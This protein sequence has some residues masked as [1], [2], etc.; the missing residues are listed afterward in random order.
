MQNK[1]TQTYSRW[2]DPDKSFTTFVQPHAP[3]Y[4]VIAALHLLP[5]YAF[6]PGD[7][8]TNDTN[9]HGSVHAPQLLGSPR[10]AKT[11]RCSFITGSAKEPLAFPANWLI[12]CPCI[13][14]LLSV[15]LTRLFLSSTRLCWCS[16]SWN[17]EPL[18]YYVGSYRGFEAIFYSPLPRIQ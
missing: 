14:K 18:L 13:L 8:L 5:N 2:F 7:V 15:R 16:P 17:E 6:T 1:Q 9:Q 3:P 12:I 4:S 11:S 10:C